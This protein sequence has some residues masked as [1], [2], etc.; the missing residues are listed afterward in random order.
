VNR[1]PFSEITGRAMG[2]LLSAYYIQG[3]PYLISLAADL[4]THVLETVFQNPEKVARLSLEEL[5]AAQIEFTILARA[6]MNA[7][8]GNIV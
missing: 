3:D 2:A 6:T 1:L 7:T 4:G 8:I 5:A